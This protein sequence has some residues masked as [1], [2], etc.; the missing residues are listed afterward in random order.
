MLHYDSAQADVVPT[1]I[2]GRRTGAEFTKLHKQGNK[3][4]MALCP[5]HVHPELPLV[6][7][8]YCKCSSYWLLVLPDEAADSTGEHWQQSQKRSCV[9]LQC[10]F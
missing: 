4:S 6:Y 7:K 10:V 9:E 2:C 1:D 3:G 8:K 5:A